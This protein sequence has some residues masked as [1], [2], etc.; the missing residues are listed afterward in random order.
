MHIY[1]LNRAISLIEKLKKTYRNMF[2]HTNLDYLF[3]L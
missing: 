3:W 2:T 1:A